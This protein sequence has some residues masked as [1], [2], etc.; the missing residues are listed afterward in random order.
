MGK[1]W[2]EMD[3]WLW[4]GL[5]VPIAGEAGSARTEGSKSLCKCRV[6]ARGRDSPERRGAGRLRCFL[7]LFCVSQLGLRKHAPFAE[8]CRGPNGGDRQQEFGFP[9]GPVVSRCE[10]RFRAQRF[11][12]RV[13]SQFSGWR[14]GLRLF[15]VLRSVRCLLIA[16]SIPN[17][18]FPPG[19]ARSLPLIRTNLR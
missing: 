12:A 2:G 17:L 7:G 4:W 5:E 3:P 19:P 16:P 13:L 11:W 8:A 1:I 18:L 10:L 6:E 9:R 15:F 14:P